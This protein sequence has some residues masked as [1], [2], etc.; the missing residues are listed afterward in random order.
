MHNLSVSLWHLRTIPL[1]SK[2]TKDLTLYCLNKIKEIIILILQNF[3]KPVR[4]TILLI[5]IIWW[6][7][8]QSYMFQIILEYM[9]MYIYKKFAKISTPIPTPTPKSVNSNSNS[10]SGSFNSN[11]NS[12]KSHEYQLQ[13]R[14]FQLQLQLRQVSWI[15]TPTPTPEVSTP[16]PTPELE[17]ELNPTPTPTLELTP[18]LIIIPPN[19]MD[20]QIQ[21]RWG[22][23]KWPGPWFNI[24]M[25][26]YQ[27]KKYHCGDKTILRL[28]YLHIRIS[29][30]GKTTTLY[31]IG[32]QTSNTIGICPYCLLDRPVFVLCHVG[33]HP[34]LTWPGGGLFLCGMCWVPQ[35]SHSPSYP[36]QGWRAFWNFNS[37]RVEM[38]SKKI[39]TCWKDSIFIFLHCK[40]CMWH[41]NIACPW[42]SGT[43]IKMG[44]N[45]R[46]TLL[47]LKSF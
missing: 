34:E 24:M 19:P 39:K 7:Q 1:W 31:W 18:T 45:Q 9:Y 22:Q 12:G 27:Y 3:R 23:T 14:E 38:K 28:S 42:S 25:L 33:L 4:Q 30:T 8:F 35:E 43:K 21:K 37:C 16:I 29:Y 13:L 36:K 40:S 41:S 20:N 15:S 17:L 47:T 2:W 26:S 10:N 6:A 44:Q 32:V 46:P 11:S 5:G